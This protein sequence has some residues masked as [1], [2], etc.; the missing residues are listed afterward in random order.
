MSS[1]L[2]LFFK[3]TPFWPLMHCLSLSVQGR[4]GSD[5]NRRS[6]DCKGDLGSGRSIPVKQVGF[7]L[8]AE[9]NMMHL[10]TLCRGNQTREGSLI[11]RSDEV[12]SPILTWRILMKDGE[13]GVFGSR[14]SSCCW[15]LGEEHSRLWKINSHSPVLSPPSGHLAEAQWELAQQRVE[16][17]V[18]HTLQ[19]RH[20]VLSFKCQCESVCWRSTVKALCCWKRHWQLVLD[21]NGWCLA[22][23]DYMLNVP[24]KEM[25]LLR[26]TV[27]VPGKRPPRAV[28]ACGLPVG[29][30]GRVKDV[31]GPEGVSPGQRIL[32]IS[33][34][35]IQS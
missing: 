11:M 31:P 35:S 33:Q 6:A 13:V 9:T 20:T 25:D 27:K 7:T 8:N 34:K 32:F 18:C 29:L 12:R 10:M 4:R 1:K 21:C 14:Q 26:V 23:Q 17:E 2:L 22:W 5:S 24:G 16:E 30:N 3:P 19:R 28:P 15:N